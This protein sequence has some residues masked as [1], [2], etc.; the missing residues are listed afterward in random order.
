V[1]L[2]FDVVALALSAAAWPAPAAAQQ[3][4]YLVRH[5]H[6]TTEA[7]SPEGLAQAATLACLLKDSG[8]TAVYTSDIDRTKKTAAP[9]TAILAAR[10]VA[11]RQHEIA[12]G[13]ELLHNA[14]SAELQSAYAKKVID[15]IRANHP[16]EIILVVGHDNTVPAVIRALGYKP[17]VM[18]R[19]AEFDHLFQVI[20]MGDGQPP[21]FLHILH[22]AD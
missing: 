12:L 10:G 7:L 8:I 17:S 9:L 13:E 16:K 4:V 18:I 2:R 5:A 6:R 11:V 19:S 3:A 15:H 1:P 21:A 22:Y 14:L 20:P